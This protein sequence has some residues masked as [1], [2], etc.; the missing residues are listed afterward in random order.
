M[1]ACRDTSRVIINYLLPKIP[2]P[3][4][5]LAL[6]ATDQTIPPTSN[7]FLIFTLQGPVFEAVKKGGLSSTLSHTHMRLKMLT[8]STT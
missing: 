6:K 7:Y 1:H 3:V 8:A 4:H 5:S 2:S